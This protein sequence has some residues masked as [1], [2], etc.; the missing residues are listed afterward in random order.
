M[1]MNFLMI[2]NLN[3]S[4]KHSTENCP[5]WANYPYCCLISLIPGSSHARGQDSDYLTVLTNG[6]MVKAATMPLLELTV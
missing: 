5:W 3:G 6:N 1:Y 4:S 2:S